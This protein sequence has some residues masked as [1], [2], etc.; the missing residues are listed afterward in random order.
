MSYRRSI[1]GDL[2]NSARLFVEELIDLSCPLTL[3][4][5]PR[6]TTCLASDRP[7]GKKELPLFHRSSMWKTLQG[8]FFFCL[9]RCEVARLLLLFLYPLSF[10][11]FFFGSLLGRSVSYR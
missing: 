8:Q 4:E 6:A 5:R 1:R 11:F 3:M 7:S 9:R 10:F 2:L